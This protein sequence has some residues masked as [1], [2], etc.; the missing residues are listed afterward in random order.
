MSLKNLKPS[1]YEIVKDKSISQWLD[2]D[3]WLSSLDRL[4]RNGNPVGA[5]QSVAVTVGVKVD[6]D[7]NNLLVRIESN[8]LGAITLTANPQI[9]AGGIDGQ[10]LTI[11]GMS[12]SKTVE[13][14][15]GNGLKLA[16]GANFIV[17]LNDV[18]VL[19]YNKN[20]DLWLEVTRSKNT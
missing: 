9:S 1:L 4:V 3:N 15:D 8:T 14:I 7:F 6:S 11:E 12:A 10:I 18:F 13:F 17:A 19:R 20:K 16:G 2:V 5:T